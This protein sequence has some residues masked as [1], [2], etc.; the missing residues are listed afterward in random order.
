MWKEW[1]LKV[2]LTVASEENVFL[3]LLLRQQGLKAIS[4]GD[5]LLLLRFG[6][7][8]FSYGDLLLKLGHV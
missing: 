3:F 5:V 4:P 8:R 1:D 2:E 7:I 6:Q